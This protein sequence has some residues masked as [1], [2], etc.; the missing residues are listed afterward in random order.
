MSDYDF[1][2]LS[3]V[4]F[5]RLVCELLRADLGIDL[6]S[7]GHGP[8]GGVDLESSDGGRTTI[9]QCKHYHGSSFADLKKAAKSEKS[10]MD[11]LTPDTYYFVTS[12]NLSRTQQQTI[13]EQLSP[14]LTD[15]SSIYTRAELNDLL[16][17]FP[18]VELNHF[19]LWMASATVLHRIVQS[20][21]WQRSEALM[22]EIQDRVRLYVATPSFAKARQMLDE[23]RVCVITGA[24]GVGKSMLADMLALSHW[25]DG[26]QI[27]ELDSHEIGKA[28]DAISSDARQLFYFDDV[29]G[30]TDVHERLSN[31]NGLAVSR[32]MNHIGKK[33]NKCLVITT[34]THVLHEAEARDEPL[35]RAGLHARECIVDVADYTKLNRARILCNHLYFSEL[36][37]DTVREFVR[38]GMQYRVINHPNFTPR[39]VALTLRQHENEPNASALFSQLLYTLDHPIELWGTS[40]REA[41][42]DPARMILLHLVTFPPAGAR[43]SELRSVAIRT[44]TPIEYR[45]A[46]KQLEG[47]WIKVTA[48]VSQ[49][50][51]SIT[52]NNP[53]CRDFVLSFMDS[54]PDYFAEIISKST[55]IAQ[56][57]R[58]L[59]YGLA[60]AAS[61]SGAKYPTMR[62]GAEQHANAIAD[63]IRS[64]VHAQGDAGNVTAAS[65]LRALY[66]ASGTFHLGIEPWII[67]QA[68]ALAAQDEPAA[69]IDG[70]GAATL[71]RAIVEFERIPEN[72]LQVSSCKLL[73]LAW[74]DEIYEHSEWDEVFD[75]SRWLEDVAAM[76]WSER[77]DQ[78]I[79]TAFK[80][81]LDSELDAALD[82]SKELEDAEAWASDARLVAEKYFSTVTFSYEFTR[83][84][85]R[86]YEK[87]NQPG[88]SS[89]VVRQQ[90]RASEAI[91]LS[92]A[93]SLSAL[94]ER[95]RNA[96]VTS[97][98]REA[99]EIRALFKQLS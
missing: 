50:D 90:S 48:L 59:G 82:N 55:T 34:R 61:P 42:T 70:R 25:Q 32:L 46:I 20:G 12:Q 58:L 2:S 4:D 84:E 89:F 47:S 11:R 79:Q 66:E 98:D 64:I 3:P 39:L 96:S 15:S 76:S 94:L 28:W 6:R 54:E 7:F 53:S 30:Q 5:E 9:V 31:D 63:A 41:L 49:A 24:P 57:A 60:T 51:V 81:W 93:E 45:K 21:I 27:I 19:K 71:V 52:F 38:S 10:K 95:R 67:E 17:R 73:A 75:F 83:F 8:D 43:H 87:F 97:G 23:K 68:L 29:F 99:D 86:V 77:E 40:F 44:A 56:I 16:Q 14:H 35:A 92:G 37:R 13:V 85:E 91:E 22:E 36:P 33:S 1:H 26:W 69:N 88:P 80:A 78:Q 65:S 72:L 74:C 62:A 18:D